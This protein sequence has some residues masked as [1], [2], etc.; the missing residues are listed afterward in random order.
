MVCLLL[1]T[2]VSK[3]QYEYMQYMC[4]DCSLLDE[5]YAIQAQVNAVHVKRQDGFT[6]I[7]NNV[8]ISNNCTTLSYI[9]FVCVVWSVRFVMTW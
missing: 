9:I 7:N 4:G 2:S 3:E 6:F 8:F 1:V 5:L